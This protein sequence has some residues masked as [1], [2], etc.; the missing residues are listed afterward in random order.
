MDPADATGDDERRTDTPTESPDQ[1]EGT[2]ESRRSK[3]GAEAT[4]SSDE[5]SRGRK[6]DEPH[7][8]TQVE[9]TDPAGAQVEPGGET[10]A[11]RNG[12]IAL[13]RADAQANGEVV[14]T[15]QEIE[16]MRKNAETRRDTLIEGEI[17]S[18]NASARSTMLAEESGQ[19]TSTDDGD[20]PR[21]LHHLSHPTSLRNDPENP[22]APSSRGR[23]YQWRAAKAHVRAKKSTL[24]SCQTR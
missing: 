24:G 5:E 15:P 12:S 3:E 19:R 8:E 6:F 23:E 4:G 11:K 18:T 10:D 9:S 2:R 7:D 17:R 1:P 21:E 13:E 20:V 16:D 22:Q 14:G